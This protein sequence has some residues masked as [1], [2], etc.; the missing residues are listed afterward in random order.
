MNGS[1][2]C[3][4]LLVATLL[5]CS[6]SEQRVLLRVGGEP[7]DT[8]AYQTI[9][10]GS[11]QAWEG[12]S[13]TSD[14]ESHLTIH[15]REQIIRQIAD[16][17]IELQMG[18]QYQSR[19]TDRLT[20]SVSDTT[21]AW[22][23]IV[24][25]ITPRGGLIDVRYANREADAELAYTRR[26]MEQYW[27]VFPEHALAIGDSWE[28]RATVE[29]VDSPMVAITT[30]R[31]D[32]LTTY[33]SY[34]CAVLS[35]AGNL[36]LPLLPDTTAQRLIR[37][38]NRVTTT[39]TMHYA[40]LHGLTLLQQER[41]IVTG[42]RERKDDSGWVPVKYRAAFEVDNRLISSQKSK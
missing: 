12:D 10:T 14:R 35:Y 9:Y 17:L 31:L 18:Q 5:A 4:G 20:G 33:E 1:L 25:T 30:Y 39:G 37:G 22:D 24:M 3:I 36:I 32:S 29:G 34:P 27:P 21:F 26:F 19:V 7:G 23:E 8:N 15:S 6:S 2:A 16:S 13:L 38:T 40:Y 11:S 28:Q 41:R 42:D